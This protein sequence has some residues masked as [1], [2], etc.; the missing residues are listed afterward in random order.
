MSLAC[1][2]DLFVLK[3]FPAQCLSL[4]SFLSALTCSKTSP[5][6]GSGREVMISLHSAVG[7]SHL[8]LFKPGLPL[9]SS[10]ST[11]CGSLSQMSF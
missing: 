1:G 6:F 10:A 4:L 5:F 2:I 3:S 7:Y 11:L 9:R 8:S